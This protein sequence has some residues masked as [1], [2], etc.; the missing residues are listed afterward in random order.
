MFNT[1]GKKLPNDK[2]WVDLKNIANI[3]PD[4][5]QKAEVQIRKWY[6]EDISNVQEGIDSNNS[7]DQHL[8]Q[9]SA[10]NNQMSQQMEVHQTSSLGQLTV[11]SMG[12][13]Q[14]NDSDTLTIARTYLDVL[15]K[16]MKEPKKELEKV[17]NIEEESHRTELY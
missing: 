9:S 11:P 17:E 3:E 4:A 15:E 10:Q 16:K 1:F 2:L 7:Q 5:A 14:I 12:T 6:N 13:I 8:T